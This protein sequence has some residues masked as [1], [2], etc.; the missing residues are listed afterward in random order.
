MIDN[1]NSY[2]NIIKATSLIGSLKVFEILIGI[3]RSKIVA[4]LLG[5]IGIGI[6]GLLNSAITMVSSL[7]SFGLQTS[8]VRDVSL[9][10]ESHDNTRIDQTVS[11]LKKLVW[12]TGILGMIIM[13]I[14]S[15]E[16]SQWSFENTSYA[17]SFKIISIIILTEQLII[18]QTVLMTGTFNY[19]LLAKSSLIGNIISLFITIP[20]Y[21][22]YNTNGI[23]PALVM[24]GIVR[25]LLSYYFSRK[26]PF[27][28]IRSSIKKTLSDGRIMLQLGLSI[29]LSG[30]VSQ[31]L[32]YGFRLF[33]SNY[34]GV[35]EVGLYTAGM[36]ITLMYIDW[37][38]GAMSTDYVPRLSTASVDSQQFC[39][40][41]NK[42]INF[43]ITVITPLIIGFVIF[44]KLLVYILYTDQFYEILGMMQWIMI[45][46]LFR[47]ISFCFSYAII[48]KGRS[49]IFFRYELFF[50]LISSILW[51]MGYHL[52]GFNG[53][54]F[55]YLVGYI[56][57]AL[58]MYILCKNDFSF[59]FD[60]ETIK[61][62]LLNATWLII[63][64]II[65][66]LTKQTIYR[67]VIGSVLIGW[68]VYNSFK[69]I[70]L[71]ISEK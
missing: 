16:I 47:Y 55:S 28:F 54:G 33:I 14:F 44:V 2:R 32:Q 22:L 70:R 69:K 43:I 24:N 21:Y 23:V 3:I 61:N 41:I 57:Y 65:V 48:A 56:C 62:F 67:Y 31:A 29:A 30:I 35:K 64:I 60:K 27:K 42:Q 11:T 63:L 38:I 4:I 1:K 18:G 20:L 52:G 9:A 26:I 39:L 53:L 12:F 15:N 40:V 7:V 71:M 51:G 10:F 49:K 34:S 19:K 8:G 6:T 36:G 13:Y 66:L 59:T 68:V 5:P 58:L 46:M 17:L 37:I 45:G 25:L 50:C